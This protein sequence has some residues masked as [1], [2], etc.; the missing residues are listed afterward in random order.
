MMLR[1]TFGDKADH[2]DPQRGTTEIHVVEDLGGEAPQEHEEDADGEDLQGDGGRGELR[3]VD[4]GHDGIRQHEKDGAEEDAHDQQVLETALVQ[5]VHHLSATLAEVGRQGGTNAARDAVRHH[6]DAVHEGEDR[7]VPSDFLRRT[8]APEEEHV[9]S[10]GQKTHGPAEG[11]WRP[12]HE[13]LAQPHGVKGGP[14]PADSAPEDKCG[15]QGSAPSSG[16]EGSGQEDRVGSQDQNNRGPDDDGA[17]LDECGQGFEV[18]GV[19]DPE[20]RPNGVPHLAREHVGSEKEGDDRDGAGAGDQESD[21]P[22]RR[23]VEEGQRDREAEVGGD[24]LFGASRVAGGGDR[25][26]PARSH[27]GMVMSTAAMVRPSENSPNPAS[28]RRR[29]A[30]M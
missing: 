17:P 2:E 22:D 15:D 10:E 24:Q 23:E 14:D 3:S 21:R 9:D 25:G 28:P 26:V 19:V 11:E 8:H 16:S 6:D 4:D 29:A 7:S 27:A 20:E 12:E 1:T 5:P 30:M 13:E 18:V